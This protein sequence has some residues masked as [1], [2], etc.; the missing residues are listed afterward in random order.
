VIG[1]VVA[2]MFRMSLRLIGLIMAFGA[3]VLIS[4]VA[5]DLVQEAA[6]KA[7]RSGWPVAGLFA[8]CAVFFGGD[9]LI[10]RMGGSAR[11]DAD[12]GQ[13]EGSRSRSCSAACSTRSRNRW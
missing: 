7:S 4:A 3:G 12:G 1:A 5:F 8:G 6:D 11:N 10:D 2:L 9:A 13:K